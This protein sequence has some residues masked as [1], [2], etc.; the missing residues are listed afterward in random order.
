MTTLR[1]LKYASGKLA[2]YDVDSVSP[3]DAPLTSP[4]SNISRLQFHSDLEYPAVTTIFTGTLTL[5]SLAANSLR[6]AS[7]IV[8]AHGMTGYPYVEGKIKIGSVWAPLAGSVPVA[9]NGGG[10]TLAASFARLVALGTDSTNIV[11]REFSVSVASGGYGA[12]AYDYVIFLT[13]KIVAPP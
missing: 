2:I 4:L 13:D 12:S 8:A 5:P 1:R 9:Q 7:Y 10:G 6:Q 3:N 11:L